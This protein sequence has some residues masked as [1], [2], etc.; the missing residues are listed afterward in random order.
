LC[1]PVQAD[2]RRPEVMLLVTRKDSALKSTGH[3][4]CPLFPSLRGYGKTHRSPF[5]GLRANGR[6]LEI[7][8][9]SPFMLSLS[10]HKNQF[11]RS[12]LKSRE[13]I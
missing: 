12:L 8:Q 3:P 6:C 1:V 4:K 11:F 5:D 7:I 13:R 2:R 9:Y 10:K